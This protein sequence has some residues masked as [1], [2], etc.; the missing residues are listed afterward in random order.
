[1]DLGVEPLD[2][3]LVGRAEQEVVHLRLQRVVHLHVDVVAGRL[4]GVVRRLHGDDVVDDDGVWRMEQ[5]PEPA[6]DLGQLHARGAED[7]L[8]VL[9]AGDVLTLV[10]VLQTMRLDVLPQ[11]VDDDRP[12]LGVYAQQTSQTLVQL[13][14]QRLVVQQQQDG[15]AYVLVARPL[16]LEAVRLLRRERAVPLHQ[17]V[18]GPVQLLVQ[19]DHQRLEERR[20]LAFHLQHLRTLQLTALRIVIYI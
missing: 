18:V 11:R 4:L 6:W 20:E 5:G 7:L 8:Q 19:F 1:M 14:L 12:C 10:D 13:E 2:L 15:A 3:L 16:H 17:V 9:V